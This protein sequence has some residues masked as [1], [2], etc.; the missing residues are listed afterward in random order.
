VCP[1]HQPVLEG[2]AEFT[3]GIDFTIE[4]TDDLIDGKWEFTLKPAV[5]GS[6]AELDFKLSSCVAKPVATD[7]TGPVPP[8]VVASIIAASCIE[9]IGT[10]VDE[11]QSPTFQLIHV[12][13]F[14]FTGFVEADVQLIC[15]VELCK[16]STEPEA[17][18]CAKID[19]C[20]APERARSASAFQQVI[21][22]P[23]APISRRVAH[24]PKRAVKT[25]FNA[26]TTF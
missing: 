1:G 16:D 2:P 22:R 6:L 3:Q 14:Q 12:Y 17:A 4:K 5:D 15:T 24:T 10:T 19:V 20:A 13:P 7:E 25:K 26:K 11:T 8:E 21:A 9:D 23:A 18:K